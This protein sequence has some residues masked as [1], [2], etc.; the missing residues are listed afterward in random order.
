M[1]PLAVLAVIGMAALGAPAQATEPWEQAV[2]TAIG[3]PGTEMLGGVYRI[4]LPRSDLKVTLDGVVLKPAL[5]LGS[6]IAFAPHGP[7]QTMVMGDLVLTDA[8]VN[9]VMAKLIAGGFEITALHNHLLRSSPHTMYMHVAGHGDP[10]R[11][12]TVLH[13]ALALS[14]TPLSAPPTAN[15]PAPEAID[16]DTA[17]LDT[18]LGHKGKVAGGVYAVTVPRT[19]APKEGGMALPPAMGAAIAINFQPTGAGKAAITCDFV[20]TASEVT[21]VLQTLRDNGIEVTAL[22]N[23]MLDDEP[24]LFFNASWL[25]TTR[26]SWHEGWPR[27]LAMSQSTDES[28]T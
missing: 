15:P 19:D 7:G 21:P 14:G 8:E 9:P 16:L 27:L 4:G 26:R 17:S 23:H 10:A 12:A 3:K 24:R 5:A 18:I 2:A 11:L 6:W 13:Q 20:L 25:T 28:A 22:H 1:K